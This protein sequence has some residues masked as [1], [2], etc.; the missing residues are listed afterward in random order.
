MN[1]VFFWSVGRVLEPL[2]QKGVLYWLLGLLLELLMSKGDSSRVAAK[3][4]TVIE[5]VAF[6]P[7]F[8]QRKVSAVQDFPPGYRRVTTSNLGLTR[9]IAVDYSSE[10]K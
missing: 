5:R 7:K 9:Q 6:A 8:K 10:G 2:L 4:S 3:V 1:L